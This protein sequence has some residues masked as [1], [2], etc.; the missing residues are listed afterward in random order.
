MGKSTKRSLQLR[1]L[2][3]TKESTS[4]QH[5]FF[6]FTELP[7]QSYSTRTL[8]PHCRHNQVAIAS[9][10]R[11]GICG[12]RS[13][14]RKPLGRVFQP[15]TRSKVAIALR[16]AA[17]ACGA[18]PVRIV[19]RSSSKL[20]SRGYRKRCSN[21]FIDDLLVALDHNQVVATPLPNLFCALLARMQGVHREHCVLSVVVRQYL[22][23]DAAFM[24]FLAGLVL[25][26]HE[27]GTVMHQTH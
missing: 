1:F 25:V 18:L 17:S 14:Y 22:F 6:N 15:S 7:E 26:E 11:N 8:Q 10:N 16:K 3:L 2:A 23:G 4:C 24:Q 27:A 13:Q 12:E 20:T 9:V 5:H 21:I 19:E